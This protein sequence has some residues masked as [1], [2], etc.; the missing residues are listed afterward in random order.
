[1]STAIVIALD[2]HSAAIV[3]GESMTVATMKML[4]CNV[5]HPV[6]VHQAIVDLVVYVS[7]CPEAFFF[8]ALWH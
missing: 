6:L 2:Y 3:D 8:L 4:L 1:M 7:V 5:L